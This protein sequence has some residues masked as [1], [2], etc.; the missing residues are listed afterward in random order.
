MHP[1]MTTVAQAFLAFLAVLVA[2]GHSEASA[3]AFAGVADPAARAALEEMQR[4]LQKLTETV[5]WEREA[6]RAR[7]AALE[8]RLG[9][10]E[11][12][13]RQ[14]EEAAAAQFRRAQETPPPTPT[15][16]S[17]VKMYRRKF[18]RRPTVPCADP[19]EQNGECPAQC[20]CTPTP[21]P[22]CDPTPR[23][24]GGAPTSQPHEHRRTQ[25]VCVASDL[26]SHVAEISRTCCDEPTEDCS[27]GEPKSCN[28]GCAAVVLSFWSECQAPFSQTNTLAAVATFERVVQMCR[29]AESPEQKRSLAERFNLVCSA[30]EDTGECDV[31]ACTEH[32]HGYQLLATIDGEDSTLVCRLLHG[33]Y[34]WLGPAAEGGYFGVDALALV[35]AVISGAGGPFQLWLEENDAGIDVDLLVQPSQRVAISGDPAVANDGGPAAPR[36]GEGSFRVAQGAEL[37]LTNLLLNAAASIAVSAGGSLALADLALR[38]TQLAFA[39]GRGGGLSLAN[40]SFAGSGPHVRGDPCAPGGATIAGGVGAA[41]AGEIDF[42]FEG[43][44]FPSGVSCG[45]AISGCP[46]AEITFTAFETWAEGDAEYAHVDVGGATLSGTDIV[47]TAVATQIAAAPA[48]GGTVVL[49]FTSDPYSSADKRGFRARYRCAVSAAALR[50]PPP[51]PAAD[52]RAAAVTQ[53]Y[54]VAEDGRSLGGASPAGA[55]D[56]RCFEPYELRPAEPWRATANVVTPTG[57]DHCD[58]P[59]K[60]TDSDLLTAPPLGGRWV[61]LAGPAG[62]ALPTAPPG[63]NHCGTYMAGWL[64]GWGGGGGA[65]AAGAPPRSY[66]TPGALPTPRDGVVPATA[67]FNDGGSYTCEQHAT[68]A[69]LHCGAFLLWRLPDAPACPLAYCAAPSGLFGG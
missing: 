54:A 59:T 42:W 20:D 11:G 30:G 36:W 2:M 47:G 55:L 28:P 65:A 27:S 26:V 38:T 34:S 32:T 66:A 45:W 53:S 31:P 44:G 17:T 39:S 19:G 58:G 57:P 24:G 56:W 18:H 67:C 4:G 61:R 5:A 7:S 69:V 23:C 33:L 64:S 22:E 15:N 51:A 35:M 62:D 41:A 21:W 14:H 49:N 63:D 40:V 52:F 46:A 68:I 3:P 50:A 1:Q 37:R 12:K 9:E 13:L 48:G 8:A 10:A 6:R 29:H 43:S 16:V 25:D 60:W